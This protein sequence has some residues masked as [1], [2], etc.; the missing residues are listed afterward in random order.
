MSIGQRYITYIYYPILG[1][2]VLIYMFCKKIM[3]RLFLHIKNYCQGKFSLRNARLPS[4]ICN[5]ESSS[6]Q[7]PS[8][9]MHQ[10]K[11]YTSTL[12]VLYTINST[13]RNR[14]TFLLNEQLS[15]LFE[16]LKS[17]KGESKDYFQDFVH[18]IKQDRN[19]FN[20]R[21]FFKSRLNPYG[22]N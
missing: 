12:K 6:N 18:L 21:Y 2:L 5:I 8:Y 11:L 4:L 20:R 17:D 14:A 7:L 3:V 10:N 9:S 22:Q 16:S 15:N 1:G 19:K 13:E